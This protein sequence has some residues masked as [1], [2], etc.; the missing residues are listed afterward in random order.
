MLPGPSSPGALLVLAATSRHF[1]C[2]LKQTCNRASRW[3]DT[4][5]ESLL[6]HETVA[7]VLGSPLKGKRSWFR[8]TG[9]VGMLTPSCRQGSQV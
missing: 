2:S 4:M 5:A 8:L 1:T 9:N 7:V 6:P 3:A